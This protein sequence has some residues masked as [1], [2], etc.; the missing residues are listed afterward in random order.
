MRVVGSLGPGWWKSFALIVIDRARPDATMLRSTLVRGTKFLGGT[1]VLGT[2]ASAAYISQDD[3][4]RRSAWSTVEFTK[5]GMAYYT[6]SLQHKNKSAAEQEA[7][8]KALHKIYAPK[9]LDILLAL[10]GYYVKLGQMAIGGGYMPHEYEE[11]FSELL[12][13]CPSQPFS[14]V[15]AIVEEDLGCPLE[16]AFASFDEQPIGSASIGQAHKAILHDGTACVVKVQYPTVEKFFRIDLATMKLLFAGMGDYG[17]MVGE[18]ADQLAA[19]FEAEF[20][21][22]KEAAHLRQCAD[23]VMPTFGRRVL[24]PAP[25]DAAY[26]QQHRGAAGASGCATLCTRK[27]L[28]MQLVAGV[29]IKKRLAALMEQW[30]AEQGKSVDELK[31]E[32]KELMED[33]KKLAE[34]MAQ[35]QK[36]TTQLALAAGV[37]FLRARDLLRNALRLTYNLS[38]GLVRP[39]YAYSWS[40]LPINGP[41]LLQT[42]FDVH[43]HEIFV[44][45]L[46]NS[47]PHAGNVLIM[48]DGRLGLIDY[49]AVCRLTVAQRVAFAKLIVAIAERKSSSDD[50]LFAAFRDCGYLSKADPSL[51]RDA[52]ARYVAKIYAYLCFSRGFHPEDMAYCGL[53]S[54]V[55]LLDFDMHMAKFDTVAK[56]PAHLLMLQRC[57]GVLLAMGAETGAGGVSTA[58][59]WR[60]AAHDFLVKQGEV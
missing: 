53:P 44:D 58:E 34:L 23:N 4:L 32:Y 13:K 7:A 14:V 46:F 41:R 43:A 5:I 22:T 49:G 52:N 3:G 33:P 39:R 29:P 19:G 17:D 48:A 12:D 54:E 57:A 24:I 56:F 31:A 47:D 30:A 59:M 28:T 45:G 36:G 9:C 40:E 27:V 11:V 25:V 16:T 21:Y 10:G 15:K 18:F 38:L 55:G 37:A 20:D 2:A 42:L 50:A 26:L 35:Q 1:A 60:G 51:E 8:K 6:S